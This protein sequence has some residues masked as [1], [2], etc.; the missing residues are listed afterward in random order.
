LVYTE[1]F[2]HSEGFGRE[3]TIRERAEAEGGEEVRR[4]LPSTF[5][6]FQ[7]FGRFFPRV[8]EV[9]NLVNALVP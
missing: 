9:S 1:G 7:T 4:F 8:D 6:K 5:R 3:H 2:A